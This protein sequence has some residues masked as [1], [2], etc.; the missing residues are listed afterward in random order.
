MLPLRVTRFLEQYC[1]IWSIHRKISKYR[2]KTQSQPSFTFS[3]SGSL[4][5]KNYLFTFE[6][7]GI[8]EC[9]VCTHTLAVKLWVKKASLCLSLSSIQMFKFVHCLILPKTCRNNEPN[10]LCFLDKKEWERERLLNKCVSET[11]T[12][13]RRGFKN[14]VIFCSF[15]FTTL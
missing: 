6:M 10:F 14:G 1:L 2:T 4:S 15:S 9:L 11:Q 8:K 7:R 3:L 5:G 12:W 13:F